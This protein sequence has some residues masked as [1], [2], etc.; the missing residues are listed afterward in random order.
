MESESGGAYR[1][2]TGEPARRE[3]AWPDPFDSCV[4]AF[5]VCKGGRAGFGLTLRPRTNKTTPLA[6]GLLTCGRDRS[7]PSI[8]VDVTSQKAHCP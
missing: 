2:Q 5:G 7:G 1:G 6:K 8:T 3:W 4:L